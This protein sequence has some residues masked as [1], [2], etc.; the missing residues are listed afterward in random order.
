MRSLPLP[1][2]PE[3]I[4]AVWNRIWRSLTKTQKPLLIWDL[5]KQ[6]SKGAALKA[7]AVRS[8]EFWVLVEEKAALEKGNVG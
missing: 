7:F 4:E 1:E 5:E 8:M 2:D 6:G 3:L